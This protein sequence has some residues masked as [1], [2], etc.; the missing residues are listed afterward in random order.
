MVWANWD[1]EELEARQDKIKGSSMM[2]V[3]LEGWP[4]SPAAAK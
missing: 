2:T 1:V 4:Y 3:G